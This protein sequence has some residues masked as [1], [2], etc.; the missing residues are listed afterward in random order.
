M[1]N[2]QDLPDEVV[3]KLLS[4]SETKDLISCGQVSK[5]MRRISRDRTLWVAANLENK[6]V[7]TELLEVILKKGCKI[8]NLCHSTILGTLSSNIKSQLRVL[9]LSQ[10]VEES[11]PALE[12]LLFSCCSLQE[13]IMKDVV[14][15]PKMA[16]SICKNGKT[17]ETLNLNSSDL[18]IL[19]VT[20]YPY[21]YFQEIIK[22]CQQLKEVDLAFVNL[23]QGLA[24][25][26]LQFLVK[27]IHQ[28]IEK[29]NLSSSFVTDN[30]T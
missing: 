7:K 21:S 30:S 1:L 15:T 10:P 27:N 16:F 5:R 25:E 29:L 8:L 18:E 17:L 23:N 3:L 13:L 14:L 19:W 22:C 28:N 9:N 11:I 2:F 26:D 24:D 4:Y 20:C 6:I 12:D